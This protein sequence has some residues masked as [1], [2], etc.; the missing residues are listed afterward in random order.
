[1]M[2]RWEDGKMGDGMIGLMVVMMGMLGWM[3]LVV[4]DVVARYRDRRIELDGDR[5]N[6]SGMSLMDGMG[7]RAGLEGLYV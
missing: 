3:I 7:G 2:G 4:V 5:V 1:M 6:I